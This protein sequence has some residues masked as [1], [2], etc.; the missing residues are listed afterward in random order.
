LIL[1][2]AHSRRHAVRL[3][4]WFF[5]STQLFLVAVYT[6]PAFAAARA[7]QTYDKFL[8]TQTSALALGA[9]VC[10]AMG[11]RASPTG[12]KPGS[13]RIIRKWATPAFYTGIALFLYTSHHSLSFYLN[14]PIQFWLGL[15]AIS[16]TAAASIPIVLRTGLPRK[17]FS[18]APLGWIGR[19]SYGFYIFHI[20]LEPL[21]DS[22]ATRAVQATSGDEYQLA[23]AI[24]AFPLTIVIS[25][26]SF[27]L[28]ERPILS[29]KHY[30]PMRQELP[31]GEPV[32]P[33]RHTRRR[34]SQHRSQSQT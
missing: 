6:L 32:E 10:L 27:K 11:N 13:H 34:R 7:Y 24:I 5:W 18:F 8:F 19:I 15:P 31:W 1:L 3:S 21:Y 14:A 29:L 17:I 26:L 33:S 16:I 23:R 22:L 4:L 28:F 9:A 12:R 30:L 20:L 2:F 25:W